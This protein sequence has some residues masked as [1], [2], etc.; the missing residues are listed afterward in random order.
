MANVFHDI[1]EGSNDGMA[2]FLD[3][4]TKVTGDGVE[5]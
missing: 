3:S 1:F 5:A 2:N 4:L